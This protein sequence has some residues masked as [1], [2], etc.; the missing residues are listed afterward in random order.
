MINMGGYV[1]EDIFN[2]LKKGVVQVKEKAEKITK[3]AVDGTKKVIDRTKYN[4]TVSELESRI[5]DILAELG[6][7]LYQ[8]HENGEDFDDDIKENC[9]KIDELKKE[10]E[11]IKLKIAETTNGAVCTECGSLLDKDASFCKK[12][13]SKV[14]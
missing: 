12:C 5:N 4:Y 3:D 2:K 8:E 10:I 1:M 14:N 9:K 7:K 13:G 6:K 11:E